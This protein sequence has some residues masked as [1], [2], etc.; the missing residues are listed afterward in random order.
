MIIFRGCRC[1]SKVWLNFNMPNFYYVFITS[2]HSACGRSESTDQPSSPVHQVVVRF[3]IHL[4]VGIYCS[5]CWSRIS[6]LLVCD[7]QQFTR[8]EANWVCI[9]LMILS[10]DLSMHSSKLSQQRSAF[11]QFSS[12]DQLKQIRNK[13]L[14]RT[15]ASWGR[16]YE[17]VKSTGVHW[18]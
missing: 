17:D 9:P 1:L 14:V 16:K 2:V 15:G 4:G 12:S 5:V 6:S 10:V 11:P 3:G 13:S 8:S 18:R 7:L